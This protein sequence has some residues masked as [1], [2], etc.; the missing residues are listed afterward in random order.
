M[1]LGCPGSQ[2][3]KH[4]YPE[5]INCPFCREEL[6]IWSDEVKTKCTKCKNTVMRKPAESCLDW[7]KYA[8]DC[9]GEFV[10]KKYKE[11]RVSK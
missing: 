6:E 9:V 7:C 8:K 11:P 2:K 5:N 3:F 4:P 1:I 10:Y